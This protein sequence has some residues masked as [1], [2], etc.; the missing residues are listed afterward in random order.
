MKKILILWLSCFSFT[1]FADRTCSKT[2]NMWAAGEILTGVLA[3][4]IGGTYLLAHSTIVIER[5]QLLKTAHKIVHSEL[6]TGKQRIFV[7]AHFK[8]LWKKY[9]FPR[10]DFLKTLHEIEENAVPKMCAL[11]VLNPSLEDL[12]FRNGNLAHYN[13]LKEKYAEANQNAQL[14]YDVL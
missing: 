14:N 7:D 6:E 10:M 4:S 8:P 13:N 1:V 2:L 5:A 11:F 12:L 3:I 9:R